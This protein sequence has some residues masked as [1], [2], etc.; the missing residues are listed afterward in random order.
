MS[1]YEHF[2]SL[3][4]EEEKTFIVYEARTQESAKKATMTG[5]IVAGVAFL[6][7]VII[8]FSHDK[9][10]NLMEG[11]DMG[12]LADQKERASAREEMANEPAAEEA[13]APEGEAAADEAAAPNSDES[14]A[15]GDSDEAA[16][17]DTEESE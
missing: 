11:E 5:L 6:L 17:D 3:P 16:A 1:H 8:V 10:K 4:P 12:M 14:E 9:P 15:A 2:T 13:A 7:T